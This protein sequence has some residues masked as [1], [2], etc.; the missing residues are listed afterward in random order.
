MIIECKN[1]SKKFTVND[2]DIPSNGRLVQC[3]FCSTQWHQL[4][5]STSEKK[6]SKSE[7]IKENLSHSSDEQ[8]TSDEQEASDGK[9]YKFMGEQWVELHDSGKYGKIAKKKISLELNTLTGKKKKIQK[10]K[11]RNETLIEKNDKFP[12]FEEEKGMGIF[13]FLILAIIIGFSIIGVLQTFKEQL[14]P[15]WPDLDNYLTYISET[16]YNI[17][18]IIKDLFI[19]YR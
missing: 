15:F 4:P 6:I 19:T 9:K 10:Q 5:I 18:I 1:C 2:A 16:F 7:I 8:E 13:T 14:L 12:S 17:Y 11:K 3:G